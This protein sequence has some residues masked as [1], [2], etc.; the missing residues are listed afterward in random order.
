LITSGINLNVQGEQLFPIVGIEFP[1]EG[2]MVEKAAQFSAVRLFLQSARRVQPDFEL[3][4]ENVA[5]I[6]RIC[7]LLEGM[8]LGILLAAAWVDLLDPA[9]IAAEIG[10]SPDFLE[11]ELRDLPQRQHSLRAVFDHSWRLLTEQEQRV[12]Q[13]LSVFRGGFTHQAGRAVTGASL[14]ELRALVNK[15]M[16]SR[17]PSGR[18]EMHEL[19][20]QYGVAKLAADPAQEATARQRHSAYYCAVLQRREPDLK[21]ARQ[22]TALAE[23]EADAENL[24]AAWDWAVQQGGVNRLAQALEALNLFYERRGRYQEGEFACRLAAE[25]LQA[26]DSLDGQR[27]LTRVLAWQGNFNR[28]LAH[29]EQASRLLEQA[30]TLL[31][32]SELVRQDVRLERAAVLWRKGQIARRTNYETAGRLFERSLALYRELDDPWWVSRTLGALAH[33]AWEVGRY[34]EAQQLSRESLVIIQKLGD[35]ELSGDQLSMLGWIAISTGEFEEARQYFHESLAIFRKLASPERIATHVRSLATAYL[36]LGRFSRADTL[37]EE[38][39]SLHQQLGG[40]GGI[41]F[42]TVLFGATKAQL[43][44]YAEARA[45][46]QTA[47]ALAQS[48]SDQAGLGHA[49]LW[50]GRV[51]LAEEAY[52][53]AE[54]LLQESTAIFRE[55]KKREQLADATISLGYATYALGETARV[56]QYLTTGLQTA[57]DIGAFLPLLFAV[58]LAALL[59][60]DQGNKEKAVELY[61]LALRFPFV[62]TSR[63]FEDVVGRCVAAIAAKLPPRAVAAARERGQTRDIWEATAELLTEM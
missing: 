35:Q 54:Q 13:Q 5:P 58:P 2:E 46:E 31:G 29:T 61:S 37:L 26:T 44:Q 7:R 15:S 32:R 27:L 10:R 39:V 30:L 57:L 21:G 16:L 33:L 18:Y 20:R 19:V 8:P 55:L 52:D 14:R 47:E 34:R 60:A 40:G 28:E 45:Q 6:T 4:P 43:G 25:K 12:F 38:S 36:F 9:E 59:S 1:Q 17:L 62:T 48:F 22:Q 63:W 11:S 49:R 23:L 3:M 41:I 53:E 50:L 24:R 51:A 56:K 42:S